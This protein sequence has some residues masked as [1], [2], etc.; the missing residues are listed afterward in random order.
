[1]G[2]LRKESFWFWF[3]FE[4]LKMMANAHFES[5]CRNASILWI[6]FG[7]ME[8]FSLR[9]G[10]TL[11]CK[12]AQ[13]KLI[14]SPTQRRLNYSWFSASCAWHIFHFSYNKPCETTCYD[15]QSKTKLKPYLY[16]TLFKIIS[17]KFRLIC[18]IQQSLQRKTSLKISLKINSKL[19][20]L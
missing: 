18:F 12:K 1:M 11:L 9:N 7:N 13:S 2:S 8:L 20:R 19:L 10:L 4:T 3:A 15:V 5:H 17:L 14:I 16:T 6:L